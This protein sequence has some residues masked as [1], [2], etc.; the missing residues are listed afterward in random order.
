VTSRGSIH[1]KTTLGPTALASE[2]GQVA[3]DFS[4]SGRTPR[5]GKP[6][7]SVHLVQRAACPFCGAQQLP[8]GLLSPNGQA[9]A[10]AVG[11]LCTIQADQR[12]SGFNLAALS[13]LA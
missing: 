8:K 11:S 2:A 5:P 13:T 7:A 9:C 4:L 6:R 10:V 1:S 12:A 3:F